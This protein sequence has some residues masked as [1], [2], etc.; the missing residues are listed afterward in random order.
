MGLFV[1][2]VA[3]AEE[4]IHEGKV[5]KAADGRLTM[6]DTDGSNRQTHVVARDAKITC[7]GKECKLEDLKEGCTVKVT[8]EPARQGGT[9]ATKIEAR[10]PR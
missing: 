2:Q 9:W 3:V 10:S 6:T 1:G 4:K 7:D 5:V 8:L